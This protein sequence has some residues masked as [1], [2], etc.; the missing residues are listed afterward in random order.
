M[1]IPTTITDFLELPVFVVNLSI[2]INRFH[3]VAPRI[4]QAG[5][6]NIYRY[7]GIYGADENQRYRAYEIL[8]NPRISP[9]DQWFHHVVG[10]QGCLLSHLLLWKHMIDHSISAVIVLE[11]DIVFHQQWDTL[12]EEYIREI[13]KETEIAYM[14][15]QLL[16]ST[17]KKV[18]KIECLCTHAY[19]VTLAGAKTLYNGLL[20]HPEGLFTLDEMIRTYMKADLLKWVAFDA[21]F[22]E[23]IDEKINEMPEGFQRRNGGLIFQDPR[24]PSLIQDNY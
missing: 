5:F 16:G 11:D 24:F 19:V 21:R 10:R 2:A 20:H 17:G 14:G 13:P 22:P 1:S 23:T 6:K 4:R 15:S 8:G 9:K 12:I 18:D 3:T 7:D